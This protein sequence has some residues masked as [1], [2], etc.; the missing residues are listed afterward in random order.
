MKYCSKCGAEMLD[1]AVI[2]EKCNHQVANYKTPPKTIKTKIFIMS[3]FALLVIVF[4]FLIYSIVNYHIVQNGIE[5]FHQQAEDAVDSTTQM[6]NRLS[7][8]LLQQEIQ[9]GKK[10]KPTLGMTRYQVRNT[11]WGEPIDINK[12]TTKYGTEEQ[13]VY[14][15]YKYL[16]FEDGILVSIQE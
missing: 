6:K 7:N 4:F 2:C 5:R 16:Y 9:K 15:D 12:T 1:D 14:S 13:W 11:S 10:G 8:E 3:F